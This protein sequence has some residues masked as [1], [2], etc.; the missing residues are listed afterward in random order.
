MYKVLAVCWS[1]FISRGGKRQSNEYVCK[2]IYIHIYIYI[3][4]YTAQRFSTIYMC[5]YVY[6][7]IYI[8]KVNVSYFFNLFFLEYFILTA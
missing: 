2:Y 8:Y 1:N 4:H 7:Y 3:Q 6:I 5:M